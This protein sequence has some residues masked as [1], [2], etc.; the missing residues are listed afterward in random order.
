MSHSEEP[1]VFSCEGEQLAGILHLTSRQPAVG[2]VI[3]VGG[4]QYRIGSHRSFVCI[5]RHIAAAGVPVLRFDARGMGDSTGSWC[6]FEQTGPDIEAAIGCL[7]SQVPSVQSIVLLG[8]CDGASAGLLYAPKDERVDGLILL[9]PWI[10]SEDGRSR[11]AF[12]HYYLPKLK[13]TGLWKRMLRGEIRPGEWISEF[14]SLAGRSVLTG[15]RRFTGGQKSQNGLA[16]RVE[17]SLRRFSRPML[18]L[19]SGDDMVG[20]EFAEFWKSL[21]NA[22]DR[23]FPNDWSLTVLPGAKHTFTNRSDLESVADQCVAWLSTHSS[24]A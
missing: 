24:R 7:C 14:T 21:Y 4:P 15:L 19:T 20:R 9:N 3:V 13:D 2:V 17:I 23:E 1:I 11:Y 18:V 10:R 8:L 5:A 12:R 16:D 22:S 6:G